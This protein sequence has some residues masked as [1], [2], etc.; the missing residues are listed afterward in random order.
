M[1][2]IYR[3][4]VGWWYWI[5]NTN[6]EEAQE[7][8]LI[9]SQCPFMMLGVC[10]KCGCALQAKARI[11]EEICPELKWPG[12]KWRNYIDNSPFKLN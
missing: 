1:K 9:C 4:V 2:K 6:N 12:D 7:R 5:T 3:I 10:T 8:L 11:D